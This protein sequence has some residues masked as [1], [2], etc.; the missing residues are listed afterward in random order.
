MNARRQTQSSPNPHLPN[1]YTQITERILKTYS[2]SSERRLRQLLKGQV[3]IDGKPTQTLMRLR[4]LDDGRCSESVM[5]AIFLDQ[6]PANSRAIL[7]ASKVTELQEIATLA[8]KIAEATSVG[9]SFAAPV[10]TTTH[11]NQ[12]AESKYVAPVSDATPT[13]LEA[14]FEKLASEVA[15]LSSQVGR[16]AKDIKSR[17]RSQSRSRKTNE[18]TKNSSNNKELCWVHK[19]YGKE[20]RFCKGSCSWEEQKDSGN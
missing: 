15:K 5:K 7:A 1:P 4:N 18:G 8:D 19:K 6:L 16:L 12:T 17:R 9:P 10:S 14:R 13:T 20:A 2:A 11:A 3:L